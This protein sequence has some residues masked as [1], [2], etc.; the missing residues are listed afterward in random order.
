MPA[1]NRRGWRRASASQRGP[2]TFPLPGSVQHDEEVL[3][4]PAAGLRQLV[5]FVADSIR[6]SASGAARDPP[7]EAI[8]IVVVQAAQ[9]GAQDRGEMV[10][11]PGIVQDPNQVDQVPHFLGLEVPPPLL[12]EVGNLPI[13]EGPL[14]NPHAGRA[15]EENGDVPVSEGVPRFSESFRVNRRASPSTSATIRSASDS[16]SFRRPSSALSPSARRIST[17]G[18]SLLPVRSRGGHRLEPDSAGPPEARR[19]QAVGEVHDFRAAAEILEEGDVP[20]VRLC[21]PA[22]GRDDPD[23]GVAEPVDGLLGV[24]GGEEEIAVVEK[25]RISFCSGLV[26]WNSSRKR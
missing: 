10:V 4:T 13:R 19:E 9:G 26:S 3:Q 6:K 20:A 2:C 12:D 22:E 16:A 18:R 8:E 1:V 7:A 23:V 25:I 5:F 21:L 11:V 17:E 24:P 15:S 14:I